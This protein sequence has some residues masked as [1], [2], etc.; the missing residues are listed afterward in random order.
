MELNSYT[1]LCELFFLKQPLEP[2]YY[3]IL[4]FIYLPNDFLFLLLFIFAI[5]AVFITHIKNFVT[6]NEIFRIIHELNESLLDNSPGN[7]GIIPSGRLSVQGHRPV[8][9]DFMSVLSV[10]ADSLRP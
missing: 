8:L 1:F 9:S 7:C 10:N 5:F 6:G 4:Y 2:A 3:K